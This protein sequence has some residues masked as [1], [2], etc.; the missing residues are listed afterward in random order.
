[1]IPQLIPIFFS[2]LGNDLV[3]QH[4]GIGSKGFVRSHRCQAVGIDPFLQELGPDGS[5]KRGNAATARI[6][7]S[8]LYHR[9][10]SLEEPGGNKQ[11]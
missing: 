6:T 1:M 11:S 4:I 10:I 9:G 5:G 3:S 2:P 8:C 7:K